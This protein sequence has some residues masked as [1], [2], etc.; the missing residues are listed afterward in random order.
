MNESVVGLMIDGK[1]A[2]SEIEICS[3]PPSKVRM[4]FAQNLQSLEIN[5]CK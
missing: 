5:R 1:A 2:L 3:L 4:R